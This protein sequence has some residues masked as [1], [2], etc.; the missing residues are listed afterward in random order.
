M[1]GDDQEWRSARASKARLG[2]GAAAALMLLS[3]SLGASAGDPGSSIQR[4]SPG[5][6]VI[7]RDAIRQ[8]Q[9][10]HKPGLP[11]IKPSD[12]LDR[13]V[14]KLEQP[15]LCQYVFDPGGSQPHFMAGGQCGAPSSSHVGDSCW[16][17]ASD[18][19][20]KGT[21]IA[22]AWPWEKPKQPR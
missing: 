4:I 7:N 12:H 2:A 15:K 13:G 17:Q 5:S 9:P 16:C 21:I 6:A 14:H 19:R 3:G 18:R 8:V 1:T 10:L 11:V 22:G 20:H